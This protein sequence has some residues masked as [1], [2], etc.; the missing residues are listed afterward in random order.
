MNEWK[1]SKSQQWNRKCKEDQTE[2]LELKNTITK[3]YNSLDILNSWMVMTEARFSELKDKLIESS[4]LSNREKNI[5][6]PEQGLRD[7]WDNTKR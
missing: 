5:W 4:N 1:D 3:I 2:S 6:K 7:L